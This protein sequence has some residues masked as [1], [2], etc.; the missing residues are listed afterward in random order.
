M[1]TDINDLASEIVDAAVD[2]C[3]GL[4]AKVM[5]YN[6]RADGVSLRCV[7]TLKGDDGEEDDEDDTEDLP[8]KKGLLGLL[9]RHQ[10]GTYKLSIG[11]SRHM[12]DRLMEQNDA[13]DKTILQ[14][15]T[16][17][18]ENMKAV[19]ELMSGRHIRDME[20]EK[21]HNKDRRMDQLAGTVMQGF[22]LLVSKFL[23]GGAGAAAMQSAP[24]ARTSL[25][26][27]VEG[28]TKTLDSEQFQ[29]ILSSGLF[30]PEQVQGL[31]E[32]V[33]FVMEREEA[34]KKASEQANQP[35]HQNGAS[36][37][38]GTKGA[39]SGEAHAEPA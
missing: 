32:I 19:E 15:Q 1:Q 39:S 34:E 29:Q 14:L 21:M 18:M 20:L 23:G 24:G 4:R 8:N 11:A 12:I 6:V 33:K 26:G 13:K 7:F 16:A 9:M 10:Q 31:I 22:P 37:A 36:Q 28:F 17:A 27:L 30:R 38:N 3:E 2:D 35:G 5:K 25:E